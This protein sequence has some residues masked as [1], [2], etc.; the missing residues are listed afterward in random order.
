V[1]VPS[2]SGSYIDPDHGTAVLGILV[3]NLVPGMASDPSG[4]GFGGVRGL[5]TPDPVD[6]E[7]QGANAIFF[8]GVSVQEGGRIP[9]AIARAGQMLNPGD[10]LC[11]PLSYNGNYNTG[12]SVTVSGVPETNLLLSVARSLGITNVV[13][14]GNGGFRAVV[15]VSNTTGGGGGGGGGGSTPETYSV[16]V[17]ACWP[18]YQVPQTIG[19]TVNGAI[20]LNC[21]SNTF[22][23]ERYCRYR[24]SNWTPTQGPNN[25]TAS[26]FGI[27]VAAW[28]IGICTLGRGDLWNGRNLPDNPTV[29]GVETYSSTALTANRLRSYQTSFGGTSGAAA[30]IAGLAVGMQGFAESFFGS[31]VSPTRIRQILANQRD[32][33]DGT[34][35]LLG[36]CVLQCGGTPGSALPTSASNSPIVVKNGDLLTSGNISAHEVGG[37]PRATTCLDEVAS[38]IF[39]DGGTPFDLSVVRGTVRSGNRFSCAR[40]DNGF[41]KIQAVR[42][43]R[44]ATGQGYGPPFVYAANGLVTDVQLRAITRL[45]SANELT[46]MQISAYGAATA[47][48]QNSNSSQN[49]ALTMIYVY[50]RVSK[51]WNWLALNYLTNQVPAAG[52]TPLN[53]NLAM[54][55]QPVTNYLITEGTQNVVYFRVIT[56]PFGII[57][58]YQTWWDSFDIQTNPVLPR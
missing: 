29:G 25:P 2:G 10:V 47:A 55:W 31:P 1:V 20:E 11:I 7:D 5:L 18:G 56:Y 30:M 58:P 36:S 38:T 44:G 42:S 12:L 4:D 17:G 24:E 54:T 8:P 21:P 57:G 49:N 50:N 51:R 26:D 34:I 43:A 45:Q 48:N 33:G 16:V 27:D 14:A 40:L 32:N 53:A 41:L 35:S 28:G 15:S 23:G 37:F 39:N 22:P 3:A 52:T 13:S 19:A 6:P 9:T 46:N